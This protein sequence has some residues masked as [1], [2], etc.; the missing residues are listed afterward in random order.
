[1]NRMI[2]QR[3]QLETIIGR[4]GMGVVYKSVDTQTGEP[5]AVKQLQ[6][7]SNPN[8]APMLPRV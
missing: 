6:A 2:G 1:M 4:G 8:S 5:V 3:Y 7:V